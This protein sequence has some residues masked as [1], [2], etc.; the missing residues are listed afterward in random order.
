MQKWVMLPWEQ[1]QERCSENIQTGKGEN[2]LSISNILASLP[3]K[4]RTNAGSILQHI[5]RDP[6]LEW[7]AK[8]E[9]IIN[10]VTIPNTHLVDLLKD[11]AHNFKHR[12][13]NGVSEFYTALARSNLPL[14]LVQNKARRELLESYKE[15]KPPGIPA[16][17][18]MS[19]S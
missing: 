18:W 8:G 4:F 9:I 12:D 15:L 7:N 6:E 5:T 19:W 11:T 10:D 3:K 2:P 14:G 17:K 16:K 13:P 1:Y